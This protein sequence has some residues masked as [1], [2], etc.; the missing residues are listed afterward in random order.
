MNV[1]KWYAEI[2]KHGD[3]SVNIILVGNKTDLTTKRA[4]E[5]ERAQVC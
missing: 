2:E 5:T 3:A 4:V 1:P